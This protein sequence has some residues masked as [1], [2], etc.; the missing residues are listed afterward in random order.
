[1]VGYLIAYFSFLPWIYHHCKIQEK[2]P[3]G[4]QPEA[5]LYWLLYGQSMSNAKL[6]P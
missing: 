4:L 2:D 3:D 1:M 6:L 5:R